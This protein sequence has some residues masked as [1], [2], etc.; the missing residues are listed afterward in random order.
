MPSAKNKIYYEDENYYFTINYVD[1]PEMCHFVSFDQNDGFEVRKIAIPIS[2]PNAPATSN[3]FYYQQKLFL[4]TAQP[5]GVILRIHDLSKPNFPLLK[6][7]SFAP[8]AL[9][10]TSLIQTKLSLRGKGKF[11]AESLQVTSTSTLLA[12]MYKQGSVVTVGDYG[13]NTLIISIG[14]FKPVVK[15]EG[16]TVVDCH[17]E[18]TLFQFLLDA[19]S[20]EKLNTQVDL[21]HFKNYH[22]EV[23]DETLINMNQSSLESTKYNNKVTQVVEAHLKQGDELQLISNLRLFLRVEEMLY[24]GQYQKDKKE[25]HVYSLPIE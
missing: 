17:I 10:K 20:L 12:E 7:Y 16:D 24:Y 2:K 23:T 13:E 14:S 8:K 9:K 25:V 5:N 3:T 15:A 19:Q 18:S 11:K 6:K 21:E 1:S 22:G 4:L